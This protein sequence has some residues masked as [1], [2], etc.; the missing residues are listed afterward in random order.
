MYTWIKDSIMVT[1]GYDFEGYKIIKY[2]DFIS[3]EA[4]FGTGVFKAL[5]ASVSSVMGVESEAF[6]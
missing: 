4:V 6:P 3:A 2:C 1:S 5:L